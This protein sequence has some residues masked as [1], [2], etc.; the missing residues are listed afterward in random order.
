MFELNVFTPAQLGAVVSW[1]MANRG[2]CSVLIHPNTEDEIADHTTHATWM[3]PPVPLDID[4]L[5]AA[6]AKGKEDK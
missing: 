4:L 1:L 3:G 5:R 2:P 6:E